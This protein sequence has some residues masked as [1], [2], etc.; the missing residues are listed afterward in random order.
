MEQRKLIRLGNS[1]FAIAL[2]KDWVDKSGLKKGDGIFVERNSNGGLTIEASY[3]KES[4]RKEA[5]PDLKDKDEA[6][7]KEI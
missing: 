3:N 1:S 6:R 7:E 4:A 5:I 2:P